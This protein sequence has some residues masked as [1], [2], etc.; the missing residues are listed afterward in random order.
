MEKYFSSWQKSEHLI[1]PNI[2]SLAFFTTPLRV[3]FLWWW[4][5]TIIIH[6]TILQAER[7]HTL[8][9]S[10]V[11]DDWIWKCNLSQLSLSIFFC[12]GEKRKS[13]FTALL[14]G[15][16][17]TR[18]EMKLKREKKKAKTNVIMRKFDGKMFWHILDG[19]WFSSLIIEIGFIG[20]NKRDRDRK[21]EREKQSRG[22]KA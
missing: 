7:I 18:W 8:T 13:V 4:N 20:K 12:K 2:F 10:G 3:I 16:A 9:R 6:S 11:D 1:F 15:I 22:T 21:S 14:K 17:V 19:R 5:C